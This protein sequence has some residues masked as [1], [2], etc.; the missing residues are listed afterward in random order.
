MLI[1][2][3]KQYF[4]SCL[5]SIEKHGG[6]SS[7]V[8]EQIIIHACVINEQPHIVYPRGLKES[9]P[10]I[11]RK[12]TQ[13][14]IQQGFKLKEDQRTRS[15]ENYQ[16]DRRK[17]IPAL[18]F[19]AS[20]LF[21][22]SAHAELEINLDDPASY[23]QHEIRLQIVPNDEIRSQIR[24]QIQD[25]PGKGKTTLLV[26]V[27]S[28]TIYAILRSHYE[29]QATDPAYISDDFRE[30]ANYYSQFPEVI[31]LLKV[32]KDRQ[33]KLRYSEHDWMTTASGNMF[34]I[35]NA[36]IHFNTRSAAQLRLN[37]G[38]RDNPV[39]IASPADALLHELLHAY[40]M[41]VKTDEFIAQGGMNTV[42]YPYKHEYAVIEA[43]R[44]LYAR[45]S[46][47]DLLKRPSRHIHTGKSIKAHCP[48]CI[49]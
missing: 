10:H 6:S 43:E 17:L 8:Y 14:Y 13:Y 23:Q 11:Y 20:M 3:I 37:N 47:R 32:L 48:T 34:E 4:R 45:M 35:Q 18:L 19:T 5:P 46:L 39:C 28:R 25:F 29:K 16:N 9:A 15:S 2:I 41:L 40:S 44:E 33:W 21:E 26:S 38:C 31:T 24:K 22:S 42:T 30:I 1:N 12:L 36:V 7:L 27:Q 49:R